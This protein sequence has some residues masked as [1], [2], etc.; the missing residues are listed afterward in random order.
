MAPK[1][2][3]L[4]TYDANGGAAKGAY[5]LHRAMVEHGLPS[6]MHVAVKGTD[7]PTVTEGSR[8]RH[9]AAQEA[10]RQLW[11]LQRSPI[12]TWRSPAR[13]GSLTADAINRSSADIVNLHWVTDG[14]LSIEAIGAIKKPIV[15]SLYDMWAFAG[16]E[17]YVPD[18][19][20]ARWRAG[21]TSDNRPEE[22]SGV[23]LDRWTFQRKQ[24]HWTPQDITVVP[25]STWLANCAKSSRLMGGW[26]VQRIPH[27]IDTDAFAPTTKARARQSLNLPTDVP[28]VLFVASAGI[29]DRRKGWDLLAEA[30]PQVT[31][32]HPN[33]QVVVAGPLP[34]EAQRSTAALR[35][36]VPIHWLG[37]V[38]DPQAMAM[39]YS[40]TDFTAVPSREDNLPLVALEAQTSGRP[41]V[42]LNI[43]GLPDIIDQGKTGHLAT[44]G[45]APD[46]AYGISTFLDPKRN[47]EAGDAARERATALWS[48]EVVVAQYHELYEQVMAK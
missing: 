20:T 29:T 33:L 10:D 3:H 35:V 42:A 26:T 25:A 23:D 16:T 7:D 17:H 4:S 15:W 13:F 39:L 38:S 46:L 45:D 44:L 27:V 28:L 34:N 48:P 19:P 5:R 12:E 8:W 1:V 37:P 47:Q 6:R 14:F 36:G 31:R 32:E 43:G 18:S 22:E 9:R 41:V 24:H 2:L 21:Y 30:L 11:R 40:A